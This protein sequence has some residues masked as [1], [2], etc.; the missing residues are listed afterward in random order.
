MKS[1][2]MKNALTTRLLGLALVF[3]LCAFAAFGQNTGGDADKFAQAEVISSEALTLFERNT[4]EA[5]RAAAPKFE[6]AQKLYNEAG[7]KQGEAYCLVLLGKIYSSLG[8]ARKSLEYSNRA[9]PIFKEIGDQV[10]AAVTLNNLGAA[11]RIIGEKQV[12]FDYYNQAL[13]L[14]EKLDSAAGQAMA[15]NNLGLASDELGE[16]QAAFDY[17]NRALPLFQTA[18]DQGGEALTLNNIGKYY[19][20]LGDKQKSLDFY[21]RALPLHKAAG[22]TDGEAMTLANIG[23]NYASR[24]E[25]QTALVYY[26]RSLPL[27][28][29]VG[30]TIGEA[31]LLNNFGG[32]YR[33]LGDWQTAINYYNQAFALFKTADNKAGEA[34]TLG[35]IGLIYG[36]SD[37]R[38]KALD[39]FNQAL[40]LHKIIGDKNGEAV[41]L[42]N[43]GSF[44][45]ETGENQKALDF[46]SQALTLHRE[47]GN[48]TGE[49]LTLNNI[50]GTFQNL[51]QPQKALDYY[52]Q[53]L[54]L[55]NMVGDQS[56][57][58]TT[59]NNIMYLWSEAGNARLAAFYGK[60]AVVKYQVLRGNVQNLD[61]QTQKFFL[62]SVEKTYRKLAEILIGDER[63]AEAQQVLNA[64]KDQQFFDFDAAQT[65]TPA[66]IAETVREADFAVRYEKTS[67]RLNRIERQFDDFQRGKNKTPNARDAAQQ[68]KLKND[69]QTATDDFLGVLKQTEIDFAKTAVRDEKDKTG[70]IADLRQMQTTLQEL[71]TQTGQK[72]AAVYTLVGV[73]NFYEL[74]ISPD[75]IKSVS[76]PVK[77]SVLNEQ[78]KQYWSLLQSDKYDPTILSK[79]IYDTVFKPLETVLPKDTKTILWS[80][81]G[82]LRYIPMA[83][84]FDGKQYLVERFNHVNFTRADSERMT[85]AVNPNWTALGLGSS[86]AHTVDLLGEQI[87]FDS[88]PGTNEELAE[89]MKQK[90]KREG[91]FDGRLLTDAN[92]T[93]PAMLAELKQHRPLVHIASHFAFRAGDEARSFLLLGDGTA[94][95]LDEM[96]RQPDLFSG[97][98]LL[99][100]SAC[101]TAATQADANGREV[102]GFAELAQ[103]LGAGA[104]LA[105]LWSVADE[106]T[107]ILMSDFYRNRK[108]KAGIT[109]AEAMRQAQLELLYG[110]YKPEEIN[111]RNRSEAVRFGK[112]AKD[113]PK[114]IKD[115]N[116]PFAH[117]FYWSPFVLIGNWR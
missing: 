16:I 91:I 60:K 95:T 93:K 65:K 10:G 48:K 108:K 19:S 37:E 3:S 87:S 71:S 38:R 75:G 109:K 32:V 28:K 1:F 55:H 92:F 59:L 2:D 14:Y 81:D 68:Q 116:A 33:E 62:K 23:F 84:L 86:A 102:D 25:N 107:A 30:D 6:V 100:L 51:N 70:D 111:E 58:A 39:Y 79:Q 106:S 104:V 101:N 80:L 61:K 90:G 35:N 105:S 85:R 54:P 82:N 66:L 114:F 63:P 72:T 11:S 88:L 115:A 8:E 83:A 7:N 99:T 47:V 52:K 112:S 44:F 18:G 103:R 57:E 56:G 73:D 5:L 4:A 43:I 94:L 53:A 24:G 77:N 42:T 13:A 31:T 26:S 74:I 20:S 36:D 12:E 27:L 34:S 97:V 29:A 98:D 117:P 41:D 46:F 110:K 49:A 22:N 89:I 76:V 78:A 45:S 9:L 50:G 67:E 69:L 64:F 21:N 113:M 96:K 15:L 17:Y 40:E